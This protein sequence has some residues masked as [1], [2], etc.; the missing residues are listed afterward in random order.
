MTALTSSNLSVAEAYLDYLWS[1][2]NLHFL[3]LL[4]APDCKVRDS[5]FGESTDSEHV[6]AQVCEMHQAFPDLAY[7][8]EE[9]IAN[10]GNQLALRWSAR[11]THRGSLLGIP[12]TQRA[13][14]LSG[15]LLMRFAEARLIA[16]TSL[17]EPCSMLGQLGLVPGTHKLGALPQP[18]ESGAPIARVAIA[19]VDVSAVLL[20]ER[21]SRARAPVVDVDAQW[22]V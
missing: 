20:K 15:I 13:F 17:W 11:G 7:T 21:M 8:I 9:V 4:V 22:D 18:I 5:L 16:I 14:A 6:K 3:E 2:G 10:A 12:P 19:R 1:R